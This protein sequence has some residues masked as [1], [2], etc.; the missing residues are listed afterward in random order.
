MGQ[1]IHLPI[2]ATAYPDRS[3]EL[4]PAE[5]VLLFALPIIAAASIRCLGCVKR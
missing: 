2:C 4:D 3:A 1:V 5:C